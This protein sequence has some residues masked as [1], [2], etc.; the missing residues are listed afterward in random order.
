MILISSYYVI[1][2]HHWSELSEEDERTPMGAEMHVTLID[3]SFLNTQRD[4]RSWLL[5]LKKKASI[6]TPLVGEV[7]TRIRANHSR[8]PTHRAHSLRYR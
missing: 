8:S 5:D 6:H 3:H 4:L 7:E 1:S 2:L